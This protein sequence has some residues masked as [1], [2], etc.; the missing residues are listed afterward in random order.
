M[1]QSGTGAVQRE[2]AALA[3][4]GLL[5]VTRQDNQKHCQANSQAAIFPELRALVLKT[6]GLAKLLHSALTPGR[7]RWLPALDLLCF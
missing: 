6:M 2:L 5:T 7:T 4:A 1:A 3:E